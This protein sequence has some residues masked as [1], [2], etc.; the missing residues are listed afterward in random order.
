MMQL[1]QDIEKFEAKKIKV[2]A[3]CPEKI[4]QVIKFQEKNNLSFDLVSDSDHSLA[5]KYGQETK[6]LKLGRMPA[7]IVLDKNSSVL[8]KRYAKNMKDITENEAV[9]SMF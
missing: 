3:I 7:Q 2:I 8:F 6:I 5:N 4:E 1:H 9:L